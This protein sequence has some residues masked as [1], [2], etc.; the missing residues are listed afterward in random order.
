[1]VEAC[2]SDNENA[3]HL[4]QWVWDVPLAG[5]FAND[6]V[7]G[8]VSSTMSVEPTS[9]DTRIVGTMDIMFF[10]H[11]MLLTMTQ[12]LRLLILHWLRPKVLR[13]M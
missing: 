8:D 1:M 12:W 7:D 5:V 4:T 2:D 11:V 3:Q 10:A 6:N 13:L 9:F